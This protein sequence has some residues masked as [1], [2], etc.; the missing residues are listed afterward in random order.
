[1]YERKRIFLSLKDPVFFATSFGGIKSELIWIK[2]LGT[3]LHYISDE[4]SQL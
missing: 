4:G 2:K 3:E 1:M